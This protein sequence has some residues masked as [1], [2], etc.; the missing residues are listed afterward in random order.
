MRVDY[1]SEKM[2]VQTKANT[3]AE[4]HSWVPG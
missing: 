4:E 1:D 2:R 3:S